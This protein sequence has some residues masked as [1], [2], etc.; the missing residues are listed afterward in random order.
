MASQ[1]CG[2]KQSRVCHDPPSTPCLHL[3]RGQEPAVP[4]RPPVQAKQREVNAL[5]DAEGSGHTF[6]INANGSHVAT[7]LC[8]GLKNVSP[9]CLHGKTYICEQSGG[10]AGLQEFLEPQQTLNGEE[11]SPGQ[12]HDQFLSN[13]FSKCLCMTLISQRVSPGLVVTASFKT[14]ISKALFQMINQWPQHEG[15]VHL[16]AS[17]GQGC[18]LQQDEAHAPCP[19]GLCLSQGFKKNG[20]K[21]APALLWEKQVLCIKRL[22]STKRAA[23]A[24]SGPRELPKGSSRARIG[25]C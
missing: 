1:H 19:R 20:L 25:Q 3:C 4:A 7:S 14:P 21:P 6:P 10:P 11:K 12:Q 22:S 2:K 17:S 23:F 8:N 13:V 9:K 5:R 24:L 18:I 16:P 15:G